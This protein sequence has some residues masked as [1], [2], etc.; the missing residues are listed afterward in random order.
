MLNKTPIISFLSGFYKNA[1][2]KTSLQ[3]YRVDKTEAHVNCG[4]LQLVDFFLFEHKL[5]M[6]TFIAI[7]QLRQG[8]TPSQHD[9]I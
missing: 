3:P 9:R 6:I 1:T 8:S 4:L 2:L 7:L 5:L